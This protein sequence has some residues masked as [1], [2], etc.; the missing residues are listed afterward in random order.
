[1]KKINI[2]ASLLILCTLTSCSLHIKDTN[3]KD[4]YSLNTI[5]VIH[6]LKKKYFQVFKESSLIIEE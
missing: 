3:G 6:I 5:M 1:M 2:L 4:N